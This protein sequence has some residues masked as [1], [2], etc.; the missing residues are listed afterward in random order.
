MWVTLNDEGKITRFEEYLDSVGA[1]ALN[2]VL[3]GG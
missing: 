2:A 3:A 1:N